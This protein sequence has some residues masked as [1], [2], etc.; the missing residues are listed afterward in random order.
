M[1]GTP[2]T[3]LGPRLWAVCTSLKVAI[4]LASLAT[5]LAM[6]GSLVIHFTPRLFG[7]LD[8]R[9]LGEWLMTNLRVFPVQ[10][11]WLAL[12]VLLMALLA[13]N[14]LCCF[15]DWLLRLRTRWRKLGEY[16]LHLG[17]LLI[18]VG[19]LWGAAIGARSSG[20][21]FFEGQAVPLAGKIGWYLRLDQF[22]PVFGK[23]GRP[24]DMRS[25][26]TLLQGD[27]PQRSSTIRLNHPL[28]W[29]DLVILPESFGRIPNGFRF[30]TDG[31][32]L[33]D[34]RPGSVTA[35]APGMELRVLEFFPDV[36][37]DGAGRTFPRSDALVDPAFRLDL[38]QADKS[39]W[40]GW[41]RL[42][43][44]VPVELARLGIEL[45]P[46]EPLYRSFTVLT[47]NRDPG[48]RLALVGAGAMLLGVMLALASFYRKRRLGD[49]PALD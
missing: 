20:N 27:Q 16:L 15:V 49:R 48:A 24:I 38:V 18:V 31:G 22:E 10:A 37:V 36:F 26:V 23:E 9:I 41:Y 34:L 29:D 43:E 40:S 13:I 46:Q 21:Q 14:T 42:R 25:S 45:Q 35:I 17:F 5:L 4:V 6:A 8:Q 12:L 19:Y 32:R 33:L 7:D 39:A 47:I 3:R 28:L 1:N 11:G 30:R 44:G 2:S